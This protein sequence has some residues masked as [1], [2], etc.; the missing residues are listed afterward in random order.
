MKQLLITGGSGF[1]GGHLLAQ[2]GDDWNVYTTYKSRPLSFDGA[3]PAS[4]DLAKEKEI[5]DLVE[6]VQPDVIIHTAAWSD[7]G[8]CERDHERAFHINTTATAILAELSSRLGCRLIY[9]SSDMV[10]DGEKGDYSESDD[11][12]PINV[13][14][15]TKL[16][17]E[18][19]IKSVCSDYV[20]ARSALIYGRPMTGSNSFS[21]KILVRVRSGEKMNLFTDQFRTPVLVQ[22]LARALLELGDMTFTG[23]IHLGGQTKVDRYTFGLR[24]A[25]L[26][27]LPG[28][29][30]VPIS[31]LDVTF[32]A[33]RPRDVSF[34]T[35]KAK[36]LLKTALSGYMEGLKQA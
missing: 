21:E 8:G 1:L 31:M 12:R 14:G 32:D 9:V 16:A 18:K 23:T 6:K 3:T 24:L 30:L 34:D 17:G 25:E 19:F 13:Y 10:F 35:S 5:Q 29:Q 27:D 36:K 33:P 28:N 7:L 11:T 22:D 26:K 4:L 20:I 15:K 2:A